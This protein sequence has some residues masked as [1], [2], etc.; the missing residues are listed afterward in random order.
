MKEMMI[1]DI[2]FVIGLVFLFVVVGVATTN[3]WELDEFIRDCVM[4][5]NG[6]VVEVRSTNEIVCI[7]EFRVVGRK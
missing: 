6:L 1:R 5:K 7:D 2:V 3:Q 4:N